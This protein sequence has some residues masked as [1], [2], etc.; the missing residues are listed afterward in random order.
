M[1]GLEWLVEL[2]QERG[3]ERELEEACLDLDR[4][5]FYFLG[6]E[7]DRLGVVVVVVVVWEGLRI[8]RLCLV[9]DP[10]LTLRRGVVEDSDSL[11]GWSCSGV[12]GACC[13]GQILGRLL[14]LPPE[15][16]LVHLTVTSSPEA[17][18]YRPQLSRLIHRLN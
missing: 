18:A 6:L 1:C 3:L 10:P 7:E 11:R 14:D 5:R 15:L 8:S 17:A 4:S 2:E 9:L 12:L 13:L 16:E